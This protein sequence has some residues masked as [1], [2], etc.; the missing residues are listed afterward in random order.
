ML[1]DK[2]QADKNDRVWKEDAGSGIDAGK[3]TQGS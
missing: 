3:A 1:T 2:E